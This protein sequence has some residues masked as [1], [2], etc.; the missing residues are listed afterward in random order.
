M[1]ELSGR[2]LD[3]AVCV[4]LGLPNSTEP[5]RDLMEIEPHRWWPVLHYSESLDACFAPGGITDWLDAH[6][7]D[8]S[9][10]RDD[11]DWE[12]V[13]NSG[14]KRRRWDQIALVTDDSAATALCRAFL[15][16][17]NQVGE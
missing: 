17:R 10:T 7:C 13:I 4:A 6:D 11:C 1:S 3:R 16:A 14:V 5:D 12:C 15:T 2:E 9:I 8:V